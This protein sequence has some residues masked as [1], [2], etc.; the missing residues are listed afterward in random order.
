MKGPSPHIHITPLLSQEGRGLHSASCGAL[1]A[2]WALEEAGRL[3]CV[4]PVDPM[5]LL[6]VAPTVE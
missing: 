6:K 3:V 1:S 2:V 5:L 4:P